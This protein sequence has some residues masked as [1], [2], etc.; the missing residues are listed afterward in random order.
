MSLINQ[1]NATTEYFWLQTEP[2]D[3]LNKASALVW[4]L[5]GNA[6]TQDNWEVQP[7]EIVDGGKMVKVPLEYANSHRGGYG[8]TTVISQS[9]KDLFD[10]A[11]F[12]WAGV[13]GANSLNLDDQI[14]N[15][16]DAA[17]ISLTNQ[18]M[19]S[20][21]KAARIQMA[22][23]VIS[24]AADSTRING[25][26]DLF[27]T[28]AAVEYGSI[29][30]AEM[31]DWKANVITTVESI[32]YAVMQKIFRE[33]NMGDH[34]WAL[35]NFIVT[36]AL[37]RDGYK[38][39]LHPQQRYSDKDMVKAGWANIWHEN[40][41]IVADPYITA[42]ELMALNLNYI[43]LRSHKNFNFTTPVWEAKT[44]LGKPDDI[45][46][47]TRWVGNLYCSNRKMQVLHKNLTAPV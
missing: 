47:N 6:I 15:T 41:P 27:N 3:I 33:V 4:R 39:S 13:H 36:T 40:A 38:Q 43:S 29:D 22:E 21:K 30:E 44:V 5:M 2:V 37:L 20:I 7:H 10:A 35:P 25:L 34:L 11:R 42:G 32:S 1:L 14:Q 45:S 18:Y 23:D 24:A 8:A 46:A 19:A 31:A 28:D 9:K 12:R 17:V 16:G 26:G